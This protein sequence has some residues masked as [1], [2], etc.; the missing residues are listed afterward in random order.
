MQTWHGLAA[1][2]K[3]TLVSYLAKP[4]APKVLEGS[5]LFDIHSDGV[6]H[7]LQEAGDMVGSG[8]LVTGSLRLPGLDDSK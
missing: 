2:A 4:K 3:T 1:N 8:V 6:S 7:L 5:K